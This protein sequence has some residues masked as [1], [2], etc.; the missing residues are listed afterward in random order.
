MSPEEDTEVF[1]CGFYAR[2][3]HRLWQSGQVYSQVVHIE[4]LN[5]LEENKANIDEVAI[6]A[7]IDLTVST[8]LVHIS[9]SMVNISSGDNLAMRYFSEGTCRDHGAPANNFLEEHYD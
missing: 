3:D 9:P 6:D 2:L 4:N 7:I 8:D 1:Y 5:K